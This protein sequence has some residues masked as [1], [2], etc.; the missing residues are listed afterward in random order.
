MNAGYSGT[1]GK[2]SETISMCQAGGQSMKLHNFRFLGPDGKEGFLEIS[3]SPLNGAGDN[4]PGILLLGADITQRR[5]LE[6]QLAQAQKLESIGQLAAGIAHEINTPAQYV[7]DN[8]RFLKEAFDDWV[9]VQE[10][11]DLLLEAI[12]S[13]KPTEDHIRAIE[14]AVGK[15]DLEYLRQEIPRSHSTIQ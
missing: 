6:S 14:I 8:A 5:I 2:V 13:G 10:H 7:G 1:G 11:Y 9:Y 15:A 12:R 4:P 3:L